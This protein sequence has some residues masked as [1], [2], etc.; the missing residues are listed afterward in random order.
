MVGYLIN[1][2]H[3]SFF[4]QDYS[5]RKTNH[6]DPLHLEVLIHKIK[7]RLVL[8]DGGAGLNICTLKLVKMFGFLEVC[9]ET[10]K[11]IVINAYDDEEQSFKGV[12]TLPIRV[13]TAVMDTNF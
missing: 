12:I 13:G 7:V 4:E 9:V 8:V 11:S 5:T 3:A 10:T 1:S 2:H 6:N